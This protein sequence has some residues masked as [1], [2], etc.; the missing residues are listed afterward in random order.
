MKKIYD[1]LPVLDY[2]TKFSVSIVYAI[3]ASIAM[4]FFYQP[5]NIYSSGL[6]GLAQIL[7]TLSTKI[8]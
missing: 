8:V 2:T 4:N 7:T 5:G 3:L 6:T 1:G